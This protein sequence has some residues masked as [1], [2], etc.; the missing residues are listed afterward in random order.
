MARFQQETVDAVF[1]RL[2]YYSDLSDPALYTRAAP[3][4]RRKAFWFPPLRDGEYVTM[5]NFDDF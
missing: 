3:I 2:G 5:K 1:N 4:T